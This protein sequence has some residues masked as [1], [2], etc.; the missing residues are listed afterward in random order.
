MFLCCV[1]LILL[2]PLFSV[3]AKAAAAEKVIINTTTLDAEHPYY[4]NGDT[5][6]TN[7]Y[8]TADDYNAYFDAENGTLKI[9]NLEVTTWLQH[10]ITATGELTLV[11]EGSS[12]IKV[13]CSVNHNTTY[14]HGIS[15]ETLTIRGTGTLNI[16]YLSGNY[17]RQ[18]T[19]G[20]SAKTL[21]IESGKVNVNYAYKYGIS[22]STLIIN[23]GTIKTF[24]GEGGIYS[25][26]LTIS[27]GTLNANGHQYGIEVG[28]YLVISGGIV[29]AGSSDT[30]STGIGISAPACNI[31]GG[32][33]MTVADD[34]GIEA[35]SGV[36]LS[37]GY[38][39]VDA[40]DYAYG[41]QV[42]ISSSTICITGGS[43]EIV[44][45]EGAFKAMPEFSSC[46]TYDLE[47]GDSE[48][49]AKRASV[50]TLNHK[51]LYVYCGTESKNHAISPIPDIAPTCTDDGHT[52]GTQ[53]EKCGVYIIAPE[54]V[55]RTG[56][57]YTEQNPADKYLK[58]PA[59]CS[60]RAQYYTSCICGN[61][62]TSSYGS[63]VF[64]YGEKLPHT[65][66]SVAG[67]APSCTATGLTDG[68]RCTVCKTFT[69]K[70]ETI[71]MLAHSYTNVAFDW[72]ADLTTVTASGECSCGHQETVDCTLTWR[73]EVNL[74]SG[75]FEVTAEALL[76]ELTFKETRKIVAEI[77][78]DQSI[79]ITLPNEMPGVKIIAAAYD[80]TGLMTDCQF[81]E[82][83]GNIASLPPIGDYDLCF[84]FLT[85]D[86]RPITSRNYLLPE[87]KDFS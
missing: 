54:V 27:G 9:K 74:E 85:S 56:H 79:I 57:K 87:G 23:G 4:K 81:A 69:V 28:R 38:L 11:L 64:Y 8:G 13:T 45:G 17:G 14:Y 78:S 24:G 66:E 86:Y 44:S 63:K 3:Q 82:I 32:T 18:N 7:S 59:T 26:K 70:Q 49:T 36:Y 60:T 71:P 72:A 25:S 39:I 31:S 19:Y 43:L 37:G 12:S 84:Y 73:G 21:T 41:G 15:A 35:S 53:C 33:V 62:S 75:L 48:D 50:L 76:G 55:Y 65:P 30:L 22:A 6:G 34:K 42:G 1:F 16:D 67:T 2:V 68:V 77:Q 40:D 5:Y 20:I 47:Q 46:C 10:G 52:G 80:K 29:Q 51:S 61:F 58:Y 83:N